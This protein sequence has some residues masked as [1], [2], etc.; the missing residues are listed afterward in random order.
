MP[1]LEVLL[2]CSKLF[3]RAICADQNAVQNAP[4]TSD[5]KESKKEQQRAYLL[6]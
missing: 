6:S 3:Y 1:Y 5:Q 4:Y 2:N